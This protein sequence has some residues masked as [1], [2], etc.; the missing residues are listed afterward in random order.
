MFE[1]YRPDDLYIVDDSPL[2]NVDWDQIIRLFPLSEVPRAQLTVEWGELFGNIHLDLNDNL[3][4]VLQIVLRNG[5]PVDA[6]TRAGE[7]ALQVAHKLGY[8]SAARL[9]VRCGADIRKCRCWD[10]N[11]CKSL[12]SLTA[13]LLLCTLVES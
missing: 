7:T 2:P 13:T 9:L 4:D 1:F 5:I 3:L 11:F 12:F 8:Y 6:P 10:Y